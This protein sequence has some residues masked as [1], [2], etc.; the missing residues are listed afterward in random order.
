MTTEAPRQAAAVAPPWRLWGTAR[1]RTFWVAHLLTF[2]GE[3]FTVVAMP[4]LVLQLTGSGL[5]VG[6]VAAL[7]AIPRAALM[8][9]GG[10]LADRVSPR[11]AMR[12][13]AVVRAVVVGLLAALIALHAAGLWELAVAALLLGV[14]AAFS[15]P[16]RGAVVPGLVEPE[17]LEAAN[18]LLNLNQMAGTVVGPAL[19]GVLVATGGT[20]AAFAVDAVGF[21]VAAV[22]LG[23]L[24]ATAGAAAAA[25]QAASGAAGTVAA[26]LTDV[27]EGLAYVWRDTGIRVA[28]LWTAVVNADFV[29]AMEVGLPV[30]SHQRYQQGA[31][32]YGSMLAALGIGAVAGVVGAGTIPIP[33]RFGLLIIGI[34]AWSGAGL[35][36]LGLAPS[37]PVAIALQL[38]IGLAVGV[39]N[40]YGIAW[41]QR[42][43]DAAMQGR[44]MGV[45][46][47]A[48][49]GVSPVALALAGVL[50][51]HQVVLVFVAGA[52]LVVGT[53]AAS[54]L[55]R[56]ARSLAP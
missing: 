51:Q 56:T 2:A 9:V 16:A 28:L 25:Q 30:L 22:L 21:A 15:L 32:A 19:A 3:S 36:L 50:A 46:M 49:M 20:A 27:R 14:V 11:T 35:G 33:R 24:P 41:L 4:W 48:S 52:V 31:A 38:L 18:A 54:L 40:T 45:T 47:L 26:L 23:L 37:L 1:F 55:S 42:R 17:Q 43:A 5:A 12:S 44:L 10:A 39:V 29:G 8:L 6:A 7:Q 53:A 34:I 13:A